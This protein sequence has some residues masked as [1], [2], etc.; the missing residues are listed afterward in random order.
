MTIRARVDVDAVFHDSTTS[1]ITV[2]NISD[3]IASS[4]SVA[5]TITGSAGTAAAAIAGS[6]ALTTLVIKNTG[7]G[8]LRLGGSIDITPGRVAVIPTTA[9]ITVSAPSGSGS[10]SCLW[11]G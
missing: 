3:H 1:S 11:V 2:G 10:Y 8:T 6:G 7:A 9:T 4:P 5:T